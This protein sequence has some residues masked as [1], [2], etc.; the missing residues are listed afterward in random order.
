VTNFAARSV[1]DDGDLVIPL[2]SDGLMYS[3]DAS[4]AISVGGV[5]GEDDSG[6]LIAG[7]VSIDSVAFVSDGD[8]VGVLSRTVAGVAS[9]TFFGI[10]VGVR[11]GGGVVVR[12]TGGT[13]GSGASVV[14]LGFGVSDFRGSFVI[15]T[16]LDGA[17]PVE[18]D[19]E[20]EVV[21]AKLI[22]FRES[23]GDG[24]DAFKSEENGCV[25]S[26]TSILTSSLKTVR[27]NQQRI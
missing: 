25:A 21:F 7:T 10:V 20:V 4:F 1:A 18:V 9:V 11:T 15:V 24:V 19:G 23:V 13:A 17:L 2:G 6:M 12:S 26:A 14:G 27:D 5:A 16:V 22:V 3:N 8:T